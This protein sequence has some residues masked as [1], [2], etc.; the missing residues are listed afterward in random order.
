MIEARRWADALITCKI[1]SYKKIE[2]RVINARDVTVTKI[3]QGKPGQAE[4]QRNPLQESFEY[5]SCRRGQQQQQQQQIRSECSSGLIPYCHVHTFMINEKGQ[6]SKWMSTLT[7]RHML[8]PLISYAQMRMGRKSFG[9]MTF[10]PLPRYED[11][12]KFRSV[13]SA[14]TCVQRACL[15]F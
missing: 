12:G 3:E 4:R 6:S 11:C 1:A 13:R 15:F 10:F 9:E 5:N 7:H 14:G 2:D 8:F